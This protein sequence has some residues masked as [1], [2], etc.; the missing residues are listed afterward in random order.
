MG[1]M[2]SEL[3]RRQG[4]RVGCKSERKKV[5]MGRGGPGGTPYRDVNLTV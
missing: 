3:A 5:K 1:L 4:S 2:E